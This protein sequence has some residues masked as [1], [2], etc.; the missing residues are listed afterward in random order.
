MKKT[1][2]IVPIKK[3]SERVKGKNFRLINGKPLYQ[4]LLEKLKKCKF[5]EVYIDSDSKEIENYCKKKQLN[6]IKRLPRLARNQAN[7]NHLLN[8]H[9]SIIKAEYYFQLFITAPLLKVETINQCIKILKSNK[10]IDSIIT[11]KSMQTW[12]W[13]KKKPVNYN[14]K[15]LPRSQDALPLVFE[16]TGLY[17]I[18][19]KILL[20]RKSRVGAKP[21]FF[22]VSDEESIDLDNEK[23]FKYLDYFVKKI[24]K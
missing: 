3:N 14:P 10:K 20:K 5:D 17:G 18:K 13:Y 9:S 2:A 21:Y 16:T 11:S 1:V 4:F 24:K 6:F 15:K 7:G 19:R 22:E 12:F 23:D 8:Y